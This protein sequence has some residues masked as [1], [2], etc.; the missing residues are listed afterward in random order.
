MST[1]DKRIDRDSMGEMEIPVRAYYGATTQRA[2]LNF[3]ISNLR[4]PGRMIRALGLIKWAAAQT[5]RE[6]G[7][8]PA[9]LADAMARAAEVGPSCGSRPWPSPPDAPYVANPGVATCTRTW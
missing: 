4:I 3:P 6:L 5:N 7:L 1:E 9:R 2:V 8:V